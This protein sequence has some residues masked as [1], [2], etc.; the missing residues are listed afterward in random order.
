MPLRHPAITF[1]PG[2]FFSQYHVVVNSAN[3][4]TSQKF[5]NHG[6]YF[7]TQM[8]DANIISFSKKIY[9]IPNASI[10]TFFANLVERGVESFQGFDSFDDPT[11]DLTDA[12][13]LI[14]ER[15]SKKNSKAGLAPIRSTPLADEHTPSVT[16]DDFQ[17][18]TEVQTALFRFIAGLFMFLFGG[19][20]VFLFG[21]AYLDKGALEIQYAGYLIFIWI[22]MTALGGYLVC[23]TPLR[24]TRNTIKALQHA[25]NNEQAALAQ[26]TRPSNGKAAELAAKQAQS[27]FS[28]QLLSVADIQ[29]NDQEMG[30]IYLRCPK[31]SEEERINDMGKMMLKHG[32]NVF[33]NYKCKKCGVVFDGAKHNVNRNA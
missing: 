2:D 28:S 11:A 13:G 21:V 3:D 19:I 16:K 23:T 25:H 4:T 9:V 18:P 6:L 10:D 1:P 7:S 12:H 26:K 20:V 22:P 32:N 30:E 27:G 31:C 33:S 8:A 17:V 14:A 15:G 29:R 24:K 5:L